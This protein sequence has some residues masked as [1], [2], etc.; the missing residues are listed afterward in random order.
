MNTFTKSALSISIFCSLFGCSDDDKVKVYQQP[1]LTTQNLSILEVDG[2]KF[3]DHNKNNKLDGFEDWRLTSEERTNDLI[4]RLSLE[5]KVGQM[6]HGT[7]DYITTG[8]GLLAANSGIDFQS[9]TAKNTVTNKINDL[10]VGAFITK[11]SDDDVTRMVRDHNEVQALAELNPN[12]IPV[13]ISTDPRHHGTE[14]SG[15]SHAAHSFSKWPEMIGL[16]ALD[17]VDVIRN[18]ADVVRQEYRAVGINMALHPTA[19]T[20]T[21][22]RWAR[23]STTLGENAEKNAEFMSVYVSA[24]QNGNDGLKPGGVWGVVKH[25]TGGGPQQNGLDA[26][27]SQGRDQ[28]YPGDNFEWHRKPFKAAFSAGVAG[29]MPYFSVP[30]IKERAPGEEGYQFNFSKQMLT[31][32]LRNEDQF[33]GVLLTDWEIVDDCDGSCIVGADTASE[34]MKFRLGGTPWGVE[35]ETRKNRFAIAINAGVDQFGG[36][37]DPVPLLELVNEGTINVDRIDLSVSRILKQKFDQGL[38]ENAISN[39]KKALEIVGNADFIKKSRHA[40][41]A[42]YTL[43]KNEG[44]ILPLNISAQPKVFFYGASGEDL[45][46][47]KNKGFNVTDILSDADYIIIRGEQ[48]GIGNFALGFLGGIWTGGELAYLPKEGFHLRDYETTPVNGSPSYCIDTVD[49]SKPSTIMGGTP[50]YDNSGNALVHNTCVYKGSTT[51]NAITDAYNNK[52]PS[53]SIIFDVPVLRGVALGNVVDKL[54]AILANYSSS[55]SVFL[56]VLAGDS[57]PEGKL[58]IGLPVSTE[59]VIMYGKEDTPSYNLEPSMT[60]FPYGTGLSYN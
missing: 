6:L 10:Y 25:Y 3:K 7:F 54:D 56:D 34:M 1:D 11:L 52:S 38:F 46:L 22:P 27:F 57:K 30:Q 45:S 58:P 37:D 44:N 8:S 4:S 12:A 14:V 59:M 31:D 47:A 24:L 29:V 39:E 9:T 60:L 32:V 28:V 53:A 41:A 15:G 36:V 26:H 33:K 43:L 42:S 35:K 48:P 49:G 21:E 23:I 20:A 40:Q 55:F 50:P 51:Y 13:S 16:G 17:N 18:F 19:D 5:E 2:Y